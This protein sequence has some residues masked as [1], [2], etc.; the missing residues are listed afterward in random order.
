[1]LIEGWVFSQAV[2]EMKINENTLQEI[3]AATAEI[4]NMTVGAPEHAS[5]EVV[6]RA[7]ERI[8]SEYRAAFDELAK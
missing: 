5:D 8:L 4:E 3:D 2:N 1:M 6:I 7:A